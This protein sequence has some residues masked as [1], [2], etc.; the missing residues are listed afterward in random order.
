M[1]EYIQKL[2]DELQKLEDLGSADRI[3]D[4]LI[5]AGYK[6]RFGYSFHDPLVKYLN[7]QVNCHY[8]VKINNQW[9]WLK[10]FQML[11]PGRVY[12]FHRRFDLG[13]YPELEGLK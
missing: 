6:M 5:A 12:A 1:D 8:E 7:A 2:K 13:H 3:A 11:L 4:Y 9:V 10:N